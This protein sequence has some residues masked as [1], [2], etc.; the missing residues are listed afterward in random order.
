MQD[1]TYARNA[2]VVDRTVGS[3]LFLINDRSGRIHAVEGAA[4]GVWNLLETPQSMSEM[5]EVFRAAFPEQAPKSVRSFLTKALSK[6][7]R[8]RLVEPA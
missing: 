2:G 6:L 4:A 1:L 3:Q 5:L 7:E 8:R